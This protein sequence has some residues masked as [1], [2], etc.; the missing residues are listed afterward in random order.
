V[1]GLLAW[2]A[3]ASAE[4]AWVLWSSYSGK[5]PERVESDSSYIDRAECVQSL[6]R[7]LVNWGSHKIAGGTRANIDMSEL[8]NGVGRVT[9]TSPTP[10]DVATIVYRCLPDTVDPRGPKGT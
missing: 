1:I 10:R 8:Q 4:G 5:G 3:T 2:T 9:F 7:K 6:D